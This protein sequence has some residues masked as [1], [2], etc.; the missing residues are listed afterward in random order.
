M[1]NGALTAD[2]LH[3]IRR[4]YVTLAEACAG[5]CD[6]EEARALIR[7]RHLPEASYVEEDGSERVPADY[8]ELVDEAG[9]VSRLR[10]CFFERYGHAM[11]DAGVQPSERAIEAE[12][13]A[14]LDG[15]YGV[16]LK[17]V[18]PEGIFEKESLVR[19]IEALL[20][21]P[22]PEDDRWRHRLRLAVTRLDELERDF[23]PCDRARFG[24]SVSR[25]RLI[26]APRAM[27]PA[28]FAC[29]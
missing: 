10:D 19:A 9:G 7:A 18:T 3:Y 2:D 28:V 8:F 1:R 21:Q 27:Y 23:A 24:G 17:H 4:E 16:C 14:Y 15:A 25:D 11:R 29:S 6:V 5:R 26:R 22:G 13:Q 20:R 12:W